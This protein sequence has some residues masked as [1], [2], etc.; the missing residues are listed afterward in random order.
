MCFMGII[1]IN[2][3]ESPFTDREIEAHRSYLPRVI[4]QEMAKPGLDPNS[5]CPQGLSIAEVHKLCPPDQIPLSTL[6][7]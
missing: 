5:A 7:L 3:H 6:F 4:D 2:S 1:P